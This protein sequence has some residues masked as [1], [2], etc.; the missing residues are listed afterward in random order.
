MPAVTLHRRCA[1]A[2]AVAVFLF[3]VAGLAQQ[4]GLTVD[5]IFD[6]A[7]RVRFTE[8]P[9]AGLTWTDQGHY[10]MTR[11]SR[12]GRE[13]LL[14]EAA[15]GT[16]A[17]L[18]DT[19]HLDSALQALPVDRPADRPSRTG[20]ELTFNAT[21]TAA[22]FTVA[23]DLYYYV[24]ASSTAVRLT[25]MPGAEEEAGFSPDGR[26]VAFVRNRNLFVVDV[27]R[28]R[29]RAL[30]SDGSS[31]VFNGQLDWVYQEEI[32]GR[33]NFRGYWWS[34]DSTRIA[35]LRLDERAVP[36]WVN[37]DDLPYQPS[38][39]RTRYPRAGD[40]NPTVRLGIAQLSGK[41]AWTDLSAYPPE[42]LLLVEAGWAPDSRRVFFQ[43]Q[44]RE[45]HWL[46][47]LAVDAG[48]GKP[49]TV[50]R[51]AFGAW[52]EH[53]GNPLWLKDGSF[54]WLSDRTGFTHIYH[55]KADG[56]VIRAV[57]SGRWDV[58]ALHGVDGDGGWVYFSAA[59]RSPLG[60]DVY[61]TRLDG[62]GF[63]RLSVAEGTHQATFNPTFSL[64]LDRWSAVTTPPQL[65][66]HRADG[67]ELRVVDAN[68]SPRLAEYG[69]VKPEFVQVR[70]RDGFP[71]EAMILKPPGFD[72]AKKYPVY[73]H[74]YAGPGSPQ[75]TNQWTG[76]EHLF[77]QLLAQQGIVVWVCDNRSASGKGLESQWPVHG[78]L[79]ELELAD[80]EDGVAWL[81]Q[82]PWVDPARIAIGG[83]S[84]GGFM[85]A[86]ALTHSTSFA[87]GVM[88]APVTDWRLYDSVYTER[89]MRTPKNNPDGYNRTSAVAA[90]GRIHGIPLLIHGMTDDNVHLQN[91]TQFMHAL[92]KAGKPFEVMLYP[93]SRHG[94]ND[95]DLHHHYRQLTY[96]FLMRILAPARADSVAR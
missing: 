87:A 53:H 24:L 14:V 1:G 23:S 63:S 84:Y 83:F 62:T 68:P 80:I 91:T 73:Q 5:A 93:G 92:Q 9:P 2:L 11:T 58:R 19:A 21:R 4:P 37:Q 18:V 81:T 74:T 42:D 94:V 49:V 12:Q 29:E 72:P 13:W 39:V 20:V 10:L 59:E 67:S 34:P 15:S 30:T 25:R 77:L 36:E 96:D 54:L 38:L 90:A 47:L 45:Q 78:R 64:Y 6:P 33:G 32:F 35:F 60:R 48:G 27:D 85:A 50:V 3:G 71:M 31:A 8:S 57:T 41:T 88:G 66:V 76:P 82:Q 75:V 70:T 56:A 26:F 65:R 55:H 17:P 95:P 28:Q 22:L 69:L 52:V 89:Y 46:N 43:V 7:T 40:P 51:E 16:S 44:D 79:G 61:R 86:Y